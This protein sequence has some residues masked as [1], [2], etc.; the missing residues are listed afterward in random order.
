MACPVRTGEAVGTGQRRPQ[1]VG[2]TQFSQALRRAVDG[3]VVA[4]P[5]RQFSQQC[6]PGTV[7]PAHRGEVERAG[8]TQLRQGRPP[9]A[10]HRIAQQRATEHQAVALAGN[11]SRLSVRHRR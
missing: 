10:G 6:D 3:D 2:R 4:K 5:R 9:Q 1:P 7:H 8:T 11:R